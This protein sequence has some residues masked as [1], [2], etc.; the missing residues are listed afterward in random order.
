M[1]GITQTV[2]HFECVIKYC[3]RALQGRGLRGRRQCEERR[4]S[5]SVATSQ[6]NAPS[7][8]SHLYSHQRRAGGE[9]RGGPKVSAVN[10]FSPRLFTL[11]VAVRGENPHRHGT[12][13][14][15]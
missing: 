7:K 8:Y 2:K 13:G 6:N 4:K 9:E 5:S 14:G 10:V 12:P 1:V 11:S 15:Q 3:S